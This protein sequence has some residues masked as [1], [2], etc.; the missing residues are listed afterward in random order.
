MSQPLETPFD[1]L[2]S[3]LDWVRWSMSQ[4]QQADLYYGHGT[5]NAWDEALAL[6]CHAIHMPLDMPAKLGDSIFQAGLS[7]SEKVQVSELLT[8]RMTTQKPLPYLTNEAWFAGMPFYVDERVLIPRSPFAELINDGFRQFY[9]HAPNRVLDL[10]TGSACIAIALAARFPDAEVDGSDIDPDA[11]EVAA[12]NVEGH[13][14]TQQMCL[15]Q[16]DLFNDIPEQKYDLIVTNPPYVDA[17]DMSD[18]P[19]E[20][21]HEPEHALAAGVNG[22]ALIEDILLGAQA[23]LNDGGWLFVEVGNSS[24]HMPEAFPQLNYQWLEFSQ[25]GQGVFAISKANLDDFVQKIEEK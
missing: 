15:Y 20:F 4:M 19:C 18:L 11:L 6:V 16:S 2:H 25:G 3:I 8:A 24:V 14:K 1:D 21:T 9:Q 5:D 17:E 10:C 12:I 22:L 13:G 23:Y 7:H